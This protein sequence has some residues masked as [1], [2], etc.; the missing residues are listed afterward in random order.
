LTDPE[1][2]GSK[3]KKQKFHED[4]SH[5]QGEVY[6]RNCSM[7]ILQAILSSPPGGRLKPHTGKLPKDGRLFGLKSPYADPGRGVRYS[8]DPC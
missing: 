4:I 7:A 6:F 3:L 8:Y 2:C 5:N 1:A